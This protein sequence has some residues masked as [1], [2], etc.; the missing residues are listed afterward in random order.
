MEVRRLALCLALVTCASARSHV[1]E[2]VAAYA[3][4]R[5]HPA[6][7]DA[8]AGWRQWIDPAL[9]DALDAK[10]ASA[11]AALLR[12]ELE[13]TASSGVYSFQLLNDEFCKMFLEEL[14]N[15]YA[16]GLPIDRP[17]SMNNYGIIVNNIGMQPVLT[18][19]QRNV[20]QP[21][22]GLLYPAQAL[23]GR[24][25]D[26][27]H[28]FMVQY[29]AGQDL[30][31]DMHT[32]DS[33]VTFNV[34]LGRNF[35]GAS[36]TICGDSRMP[37][38]RLFFASYVHVVGRCL[39]HL[40]SRR[41]GADDIREG[42]RNNLIIWNSNSAYRGSAKYVNNQPYHKEAAAPDPRCLSY[43]HDRDFGQFLDYP[44]GKAD[45]R[46]RG[47][48]PPA[49]ACYDAMEPALGGRGARHDEL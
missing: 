15:F 16:S 7:F 35:S 48:C 32:D 23:E 3:P 31:L 22:A 18:A 40:G 49:F 45:F 6:L 25:F 38:H 5:K 41:H 2:V 8:A 47:W 33:D 29:K 24:G 13:D 12:E 4:L 43:T 9:L 14:D 17:N 19:L 42:E 20:L 46:G 21:I 37:D 26:G 36:L 28:S 1:Q 39:V 11:L 44:P 10:N 27:H 34:C 30:G